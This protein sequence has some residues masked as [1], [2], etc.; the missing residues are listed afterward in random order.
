[1]RSIIKLKLDKV[2]RRIA[3]HYGATLAYSP[4]LVSSRLESLG[5][6]GRVWITAETF[7]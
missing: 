5:V 6:G 1:M 4:E 2:A 7:D 3:D